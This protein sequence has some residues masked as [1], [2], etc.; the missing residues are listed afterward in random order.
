MVDFIQ[1]MKYAR[2]LILFNSQRP[3]RAKNNLN[4]GLIKTVS[5][6]DKEAWY[7]GK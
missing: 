4:S 3:F 6:E 7:P 5:S 2:I 1:F